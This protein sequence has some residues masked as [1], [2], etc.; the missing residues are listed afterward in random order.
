MSM[1]TTGI[2]SYKKWNYSNSLYQSEQLH[3]VIMSSTLIELGFSFL[4]SFLLHRLCDK[5]MLPVFLSLSG[6]LIGN[7][8]I[9][10]GG[11]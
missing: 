6:L 3:P 2:L 11:N 5:L 4:L 10:T 1:P 8:G 7:L 9:L